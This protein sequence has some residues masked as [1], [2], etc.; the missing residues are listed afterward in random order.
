[1]RVLPALA[2]L[3]LVVASP[4]IAADPPV[5]AGKDPGGP[6]VALI[7]AGIDYTAPDVARVL[8][9]DGEGELVGW[10][11]VDNDHRPYAAAGGTDDTQLAK[12]FSGAGLRMVPIRADLA[13]PLSL[14]RGAA[15]AGKTPASIVI[16]PVV[17]R[18]PDDLVPFRTV[19]QH[20]KDI[21]FV[22]LAAGEPLKPEEAAALATPNVVPLTSETC[23]GRETR[24]TLKEVLALLCLHPRKP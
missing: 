19:A 9:R 14:A 13:D 23:A 16:V 12:M 21:V 4:A 7:T 17:S 20:L 6:A 10:D 18:R 5:P 22:V 8:A 1:M 11:F 24:E 15:F 3:A 2:A